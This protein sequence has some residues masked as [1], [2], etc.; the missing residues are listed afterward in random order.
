V[1]NHLINHHTCVRIFLTDGHWVKLP[2]SGSRADVHG[3]GI[4]H[5]RFVAFETWNE[6]LRYK[7]MEDA[8]DADRC[9]FVVNMINALEK[10]YP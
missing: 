10:K 6:I 9:R 8:S 2:F 4:V 1:H 5:V 3:T 7:E